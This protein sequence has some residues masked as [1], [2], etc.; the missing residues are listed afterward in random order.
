M[1]KNVDIKPLFYIEKS[2]DKRESVVKLLT[3]LENNPQL[4]DIQSDIEAVLSFLNEYRDSPETL[5]SYTTELERLL[6]WCI[7]YANMNITSLKREQLQSYQRFL[8]RPTPKAQWCGVSVG[9]QL[10]SGELNANWRPLV[11]GLSASSMSK[12]LNILDSFFNYLVQ[13]EYLTG[14]PLA[15]DRR[16]KKRQAKPRII[17]RYLELNEIRTVLDALAHYALHPHDE[18]GVFQ[19]LRARYIIMLLFYTGLRIS[20]AAH[21]RMGHFLQREKQWFLRVT[22]KGKK[23]RDIPIP[24]EL[25]TVLGDFRLAVG[26]KKSQPRFRE[27][28]P[29]IPMQNLTHPI[30]PR[31][32]DQILRWAFDMGA[33]QLESDHPRKASKLRAA[34]AHW[35][36]HSYVTYLLESGAPLKVAQEN[37]GHSDVGTTMHYRHVAQ[38]DRHA[39]TK[40]LSLTVDSNKSDTSD[41]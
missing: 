13:T 19:V 3:A 30:S 5:R 33:Q 28:T 39:A 14:N 25:L 31:R 36:R 34:S 7:Y 26:L 24:N 40:G 6:L 27:R 32:I 2:K 35:L 21:H 37:A 22:G 12:V 29:L 4:T 18:R 11:K 1:G 38:T 16:R 20:E 9:K 41:V 23:V 15:L 10:K 17:D 8:K